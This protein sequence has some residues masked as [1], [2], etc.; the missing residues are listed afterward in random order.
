MWMIALDPKD[1]SGSSPMLVV[2]VGDEARLKSSVTGTAEVLVHGGFAAVGSRA[3]VRVAGP[4]ALSNLV[5]QATPKELGLVVHV[6]RA[7]ASHGSD[8]EGAL[9]SMG[10]NGPGEKQVVDGT[11]GILRQ[12]ERLEGTLTAGAGGLSTWGCGVAV[13][14]SSLARFES[15]LQPTD[16]G[17]AARL[18]GD[19]PMMIA[20]RL[21]MGPFKAAAV[22]LLAAQGGPAGPISQVFELIGTELALGVGTPVGPNKT[23]PVRGSIGL[24][25]GAAAAT[26]L[27]TTVGAIAQGGPKSWSG[28]VGTIKPGKA[29]GKAVALHEISF[30]PAKDAS[31]ADKKAHAAAWPKGLSVVLGVAG[32]ELIVALERDSKKV[33]AELVKNAGASIKPKYGKWTADA[34]AASVERKESVLML[35]DAA[36]WAAVSQHADAATMPKPGARPPLAIGFGFDGGKLTGR[37]HLPIEQVTAL[38]QRK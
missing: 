14:K 10:G 33:A 18:G 27:A 29:T 24:T 12:V 21:D 34:I 25:D 15:V 9:R 36:M 8:I 30:A 32:N 3:A 26:L 37:V 7:L 20:S 19:F 28:L 5:K 23:V 2:G 1:Q 22:Q 11:V 13:A 17:F 31:A 35:D 4:W 38:A 6:A 16:Y